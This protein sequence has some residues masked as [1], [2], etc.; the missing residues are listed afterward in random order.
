MSAY[1]ISRLLKPWQRLIAWPYLKWKIPALMFRNTYEVLS[2]LTSDADLIAVLTGQWGDMGL[3][4]KRSAFMVH[5]MIARHYMHG[6]FYPIGGS[7][8]M[9]ETIIPQIQ[10]TGGEVF[11]YARVKH[12]VLDGQRVTGVEMSDG[13]LIDCACVIDNTFNSLLPA[14]AVQEAGYKQLLEQVKPSMAHLGIYIGLKETAE[15]LGLPKT[16]FWLYHS[17]D[18]DAAV[19]RFME[20]P[21]APFPVVYISFPSAKDPDYERRHPGTATIEIVAPAPFQWF[22]KWQGTTWGQRGDDYDE[23]KAQLGERLMQ[24]LYDKLPQL[25]GKVDY[26][27]VSTPLSTDHFC[28]YRHGELYGLDHDPTRLQQTWLG[29]RTRIKGLWLTGQDVLTC[30][31]TGAMMAGLLTSTAIIG[32]RKATTLM[33]HIY[34]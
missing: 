9:A 31:V 18:S 14:D 24:H 32:P 15:Q 26:F 12:I 8:Q 34:S 33:K 27:E 7:W 25:K 28:A 19:E 1:G 5:A 22:E 4:P 6:G 2:E 21:Q 10:K 20:D 16:N 29:P 17:N 11:T 3:P 13:H 23:F 30:G